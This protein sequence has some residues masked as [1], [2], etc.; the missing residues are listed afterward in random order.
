[1]RVRVRGSRPVRHCRRNTL[2]G[3]I[4]GL[5]AARGPGI[6]FLEYLTPGDGR[7]YPPGA[8][9]NDL[10]WWSTRLVAADGAR[11]EA[12]G[13]GPAADPPGDDLGFDRGITV[14]D[15]DGHDLEIV[16]PAKALT[17]RP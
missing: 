12:L 2:P 3:V 16:E 15:P 1:M 6:E 9:A 11:L 14:R 10:V 17:M 4:T 5:R 13:E 7:P 8:R